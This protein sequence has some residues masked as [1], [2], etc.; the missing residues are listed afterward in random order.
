MLGTHHA[1]RAVFAREN[2]EKWGVS[3]HEAIVLYCA[4]E[5][6]LRRT[7]EWL[8]SHDWPR[9][10]GKYRCRMIATG[11]APYGEHITWHF[12][13]RE[14]ICFHLDTKGSIWEPAPIRSGYAILSPWRWSRDDLEFF[15][16]AL[17]DFRTLK[18]TP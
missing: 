16:S 12:C 6:E 7:L 5:N 10:V 11:A 13:T 4:Y 18:P 15:T 9:R 3:V 1:E 17:R 8:A 2:A 14:G